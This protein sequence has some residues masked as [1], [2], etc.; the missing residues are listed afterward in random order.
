[1]S[2]EMKI[3]SLASHPSSPP[4]T[5]PGSFPRVCDLGFYTKAPIKGVDIISNVSGEPSLPTSWIYFSWITEKI[6]PLDCSLFLMISL[7]AEVDALQHFSVAI[8]RGGC[9]P[10]KH[11]IRLKFHVSHRNLC[12]MFES[13]RPMQSIFLSGYYPVLAFLG[14]GFIWIG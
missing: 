11:I 2:T 9:S 12:S 10:L 6:Y 1:M 4:S 8:V 3:T 5:F 7:C 14:C 13:A